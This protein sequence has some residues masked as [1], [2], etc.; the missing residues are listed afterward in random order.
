MDYFWD[1][2][3]GCSLGG[4]S[5]TMTEKMAGYTEQ[6]HPFNM[7][8]ATLE[9]IHNLLVE[10]AKASTLVITSCK[11]PTELAQAL[12]LKRR[13]AWQIYLQSVFL[14][15]KEQQ[16]PLITL[17]ETIEVSQSPTGQRIYTSSEEISIDKFLITLLDYLQENKLFMPGKNDPRHAFARL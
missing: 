4:A 10:Y 14:L 8:F 13:Y 1:C 11:T 17:F 12:E 9:R 15:E 2:S 16:Q 6:G 7:A 5:N 3:S